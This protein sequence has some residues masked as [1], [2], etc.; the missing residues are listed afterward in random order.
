MWIG[1]PWRAANS[2]Q[3]NVLRDPCG[4]IVPH[5]NFAEL[6]ESAV[7]ATPAAD[8]P[9]LVAD[10]ARAQARALTRLTAS[11]APPNEPTPQEQEV[12]LTVS[13]AAARLHV[14]R[15]WI[16]RNWQSLSGARKLGHR[17]LRFSSRALDAWLEKRGAK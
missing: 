3:P 6:V 14:P 2:L 4:R 11:S 8:L 10:L 7:D 15:S 16:Y 12:L 17:T 1:S 5:M 13:E 9:A